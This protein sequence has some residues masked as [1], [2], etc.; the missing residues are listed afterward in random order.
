MIVV[1]P[2]I[3]AKAGT[4]SFHEAGCMGLAG[5][6]SGTT[7]RPKNWFPAFAGMNGCL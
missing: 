6:V 3:P 4:Q 5:R 2:L 1:T 7:D